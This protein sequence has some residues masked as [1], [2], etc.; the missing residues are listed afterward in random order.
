MLVINGPW[1]RRK[2][3]DDRCNDLVGL[4]VFDQ[5]VPDR[6]NMMG[7][8]CINTGNRFARAVEREDSMNFIAVMLWIFHPDDRLYTAVG[9]EQRFH[10]FLLFA[11]LGRIRQ[12]Q[13]LTSAT[14]FRLRTAKPD[15]FSGCLDLFCAICH[16]DSSR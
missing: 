7:S 8:C 16:N 3:V 1:E 5:A 11:E 4:F 2:K 15:A 13:K 9:R 12:F 6:N 10:P 14:C